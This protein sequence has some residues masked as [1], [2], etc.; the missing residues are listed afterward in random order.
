M[1]VGCV[2]LISTEQNRA[3]GQLGL[4]QVE[5]V[6]PHPHQAGPLP[7]GPPRDGG[8]QLLTSSWTSTASQVRHTFTCGCFSSV[9]L[10]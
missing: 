4:S 1:G 3:E 9:C 5:L 2:L 10:G 6:Q 7:P 8:P